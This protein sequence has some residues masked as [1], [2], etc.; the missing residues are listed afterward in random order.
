MG[1]NRDEE[2]KYFRGQTTKER[3]SLKRIDMNSN[4]PLKKKKN[5]NN[6]SR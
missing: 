5:K 3:A 1:E 6:S 2:I 4:T